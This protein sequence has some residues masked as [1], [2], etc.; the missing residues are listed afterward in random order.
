MQHEPISR[1]HWLLR[2]T[3]WLTASVRLFDMGCGSGGRPTVP[4]PVPDATAPTDTIRT[5]A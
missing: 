5:D 4:D 2:F 3:F 1:G